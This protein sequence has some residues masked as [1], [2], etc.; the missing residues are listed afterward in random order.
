MIL[1]SAALLIIAK[2]DPLKYL[3]Q[4]TMYP[5]G[6]KE[7]DKYNPYAEPASKMP[8]LAIERTLIDKDN[9]KVKPGHYLATISKDK[10]YIML[11]SNDN[12]KGVFLINDFTVIEKKL[13]VNS[14]VLTIKENGTVAQIQVCQ[15]I[16][17]ATAQIKLLP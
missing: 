4:K 12:L 11:F 5:S 3:P 7:I 15:D 17:I 9:N 10:Q 6:T 8:L 13:K 2:A 16:F 1:E 14:A